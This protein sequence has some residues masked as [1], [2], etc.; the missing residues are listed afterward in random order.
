MGS[1]SLQ[2]SSPAE[3]E[4]YLSVICLLYTLPLGFRPTWSPSPLANLSLMLSI[5]FISSPNQGPLI[6]LSVPCPTNSAAFIV[7]SVCPSFLLNLVCTPWGTGLKKGDMIKLGSWVMGAQ[8][9]SPPFPGPW[10]SH[11]QKR[12]T[13]PYFVVGFWAIERR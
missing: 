6:C 11:L 10:F 8:V 9:K 5:Y 3:S 7:S 1:C 2:S 12:D 4:C 13:I